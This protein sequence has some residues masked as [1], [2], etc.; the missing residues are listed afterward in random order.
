[1]IETYLA[2]LIPPAALCTTLYWGERGKQGEIQIR[3][4]EFKRRPQKI[5]CNRRS[6]T[7]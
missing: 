3:D 5:L 4:L 1:M 2:R 7:V 6:S